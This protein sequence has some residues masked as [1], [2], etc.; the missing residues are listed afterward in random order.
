VLADIIW[1]EGTIAIVLALG[2]PIV[3]IVGWFWY[4]IAKTTSEND[5]KRS[6]VERGMSADEIERVMSA[7]SKR[8][9][10]HSNKC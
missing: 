9:E 4:K 6:L 5:L 10:R 1:N 8:R 2:I 7:G 3:A